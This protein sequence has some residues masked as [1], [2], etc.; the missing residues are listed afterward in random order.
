MNH[1]HALTRLTGI[2]FLAATL[3]LSASLISPSSAHAALINE[4]EPLDTETAQP[5]P[6]VTIQPGQNWRDPMSEVNLLWIA[7]GCFDMGSPPRAEGRESDEGPVHQACVKGFWLGETEVT[8]GQWRRVMHNNP[9]RFR[10]GENYPVENVTREEVNEFIAQLN[11]RA[12]I[13]VQ[14]RLPSEAEWEFACRNGGQRTI[15][16]G[17]SDPARYAWFA[18]NSLATSQPVGLRPANQLGLKDMSGNVWEW[19][20]ERYQSSYA[21]DNKSAAA[22][23]AGGVEFFTIRG[24]G[25]QDEAQSLRCANRGFQ[26]DNSRRPDL[27]LRLAASVKTKEKKN[28]TRSTDTRRMPF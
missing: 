12:R 22:N 15:F 13:N 7:G 27:G 10:K 2:R 5:K 19:V 21:A 8:Q 6:A 3:T 26:S 1:S 14:F 4:W 24:G 20:Q 18:P 11:S 17:G 9:S 16:P 23:G 25:W 28:G